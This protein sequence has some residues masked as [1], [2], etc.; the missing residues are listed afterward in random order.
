MQI[1]DKGVVYYT[2]FHES[3]RN[4]FMNERVYLKNGQ[5]GRIQNEDF[6]IL[7][8]TNPQSSILLWGNGFREL[9]KW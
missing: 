9:G 8:T 3:Q 4:S 5:D 6:F 1:L 7:L 2:Y